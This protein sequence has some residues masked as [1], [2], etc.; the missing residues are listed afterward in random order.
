MASPKDI[1][2]LLPNSGRKIK[3]LPYQGTTRGAFD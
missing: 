2:P 1:S 3:E